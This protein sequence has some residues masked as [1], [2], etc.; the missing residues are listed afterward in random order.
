MNELIQKLQS[1]HGLSAE[2]AHGVLETVTGYI[3]EKV[4]MASGMLDNF[5]HPTAG[6][7]GDSSPLGT[8]EGVVD[9]I[10]DFAKEKLGGFFGGNK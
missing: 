10:E 4:P 7:S 2:Q 5:L 1:L 6:S 9:K 3:K 8:K